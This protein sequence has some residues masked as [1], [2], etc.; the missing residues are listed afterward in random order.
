MQT[1]EWSNDFQGKEKIHLVFYMFVLKSLGLFFIESMVMWFILL[2][3]KMM[4]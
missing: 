4:F 3:L 1:S 2:F